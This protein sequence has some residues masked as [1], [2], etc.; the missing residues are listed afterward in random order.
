MFLSSKTTLKKKRKKKTN[1][2]IFAGKL[3]FLTNIVQVLEV[4]FLFF[5][6]FLFFFKCV[7][8]GEKK[9]K[10]SHLEHTHVRSNDP[11]YLWP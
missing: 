11:T 6:L 8:E 2:L 5:F 7:L 10:I 3:S 1:K 4:F 9:I